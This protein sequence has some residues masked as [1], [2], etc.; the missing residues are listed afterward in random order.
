MREIHDYRLITTD[1]ENYFVRF[2]EQITEN[3]GLVFGGELPLIKGSSLEELFT[4][5]EEV[6]E[7]FT[8]PVIL[9]GLQSSE[10]KYYMDLPPL[11]GGP[12]EGSHSD[13][14]VQQA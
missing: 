6:K 2:V 3:G 11:E 5:L 10:I 13:E 14:S 7:A 9:V 8:K 4:T 1:E 12:R